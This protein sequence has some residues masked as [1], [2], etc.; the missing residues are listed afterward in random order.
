MG[1]KTILV[2]GKRQI[3]KF[4]DLEITAGHI[5]NIHMQKL[6]VQILLCSQVYKY[7]VI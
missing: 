4:N 1:L 5:D 6:D 3:D 7:V 2:P